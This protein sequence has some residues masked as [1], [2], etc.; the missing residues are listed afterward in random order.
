MV[1]E[2]YITRMHNTCCSFEYSCLVLS[3][4]PENPHY[5]FPS[6]TTLFALHSVFC[7]DYQFHALSCLFTKECSTMCFPLPRISYTLSFPAFSCTSYSICSF[8][9]AISR[10][11]N[12]HRL[13]DSVPFSC[14]ML[15]VS[16]E[17]PTMSPLPRTLPNFC[18]TAFFN[19]S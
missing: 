15:S 17:F 7:V 4:C 14:P 13:L 16:R 11:S 9:P 12:F 2:P 19:K 8:L 5:V 3:V 18:F 10:T 6:L 1:T